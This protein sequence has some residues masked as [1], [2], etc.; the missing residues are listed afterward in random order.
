M[1]RRIETQK[2]LLFLESAL[3]VAIM[4]A[5]VVVVALQ[6]FGMMGIIFVLVG[7]LMLAFVS[8]SRGQPPI[9]DNLIA[10]S[11]DQGRHIYEILDELISKTQLKQNPSV[12]LLAEDMMNAATLETREGPIIVLTPSTANKLNTRQLRGILA[13][14]VAHLEFR[15]TVLLKLTLSVHIITQSIANVA[16]FMLILFFPLL[17]L[18]EGTFPLHLL[19]IL[20]G[21]PIASVLLQLAFSR[22]RELNAD[23]GA[24]ELT[25][26]PEGLAD[27]LERIDRVQSH[28]I[29]QLFPFKRPKQPGSIFRSHPDIPAR[30][31]RLRKIAREQKL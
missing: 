1:A 3:I 14:E 15:D 7:V 5:L 16:W 21:A 12:Y 13:H 25:N 8:Q 22:S 19:L 6:V 29:S 4:V 24:L 28:T 31:K 2:F 17:I 30:I 9:P 26:D 27:A 23:L 11:R 10:V 18:S 20:F